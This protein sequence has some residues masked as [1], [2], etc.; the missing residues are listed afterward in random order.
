MK[1]EHRPCKRD[2]IDREKKD[3]FSLYQRSVYFDISFIDSFFFFSRENHV[4]I[5]IESTRPME[6]CITANV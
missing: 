1:S 3:Q 2:A 4:Q 6:C 5:D